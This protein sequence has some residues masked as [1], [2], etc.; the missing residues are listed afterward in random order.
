MVRVRLLAD[1][2]LAWANEVY[3]SIEFVPTE[4]GDV[5]VV[6]EVDGARVG[7]GRL[8]PVGEGALELGGIWT[9]EVARGK[10]VA[11]AVVD[12]LIARAAGRDVW[13]VPFQHLADYYARFGFERTERPWPA[14]V[15][16]KMSACVAS[17]LP[18]ATVMRLRAA[19]SSAPRRS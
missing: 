12:D 17:K 9:D 14:G 11:K 19:S 10:G 1:A 16:K 18:P 6:A 3:R 2:E 5:A 7:L 13:C 4:V 8:V 15:E